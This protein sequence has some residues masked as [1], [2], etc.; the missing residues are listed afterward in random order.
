MKTAF[1]I[2]MKIP[3]GI[4]VPTFTLFDEN[5]IDFEAN[6]W[7]IR[8]IIKNGA[9][10]LFTLG[11]TGS[12]PYFMDHLDDCRK[13]VEQ[14]FQHAQKNKI[15]TLVGVY[16]E[17]PQ[18]I[19]ENAKYIE[20]LDESIFLVIPPPL[21]NHLP[22]ETQLNFFE[23]VCE[24]LTNPVILYNNPVRFAQTNLDPELCTQLKKFDNFRGLKD[25]S[26]EFETKLAYLEHLDERCSISCGKEGMI[27]K[28]FC[29]IEKDARKY[30]GCIP[31]IS[32]VINL[33]QNLWKKALQGDDEKVMAL[34]NEINSFRNKIYHSEIGKGKAQRG[35]KVALRYT[36]EQQEN[37][38]RN[39]P[40]KVAP[41]LEQPMP[42]EIE[43]RIIETVTW[44]LNQ[45][46][47]S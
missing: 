36:Y 32:N 41:D 7:L 9:D 21:Q 38:D 10:G 12:G 13:L 14:T 42:L 18:E 40:I 34:Q 11:S 5:G 6:D 4:I 25:S 8:H 22:Q 1:S 37:R 17:N 3:S 27:G 23:R 20:N 28:F 46:Y 39:I 33:F 45:G 26:A 29:A 30:A 2:D 44:C 16:G 19:I 31:S 47:I 15:A 43:K 35:G 24:G